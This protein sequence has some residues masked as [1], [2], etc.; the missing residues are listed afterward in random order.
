MMSSVSVPVM[1]HAVSSDV[2]VMTDGSEAEAGEGG[3]SV[4]VCSEVSILRLLA[5]LS[6][7][8][9]PASPLR[10]VPLSKFASI[11]TRLHPYRTPLWPVNVL[12]TLACR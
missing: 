5:S 8:P 6:S 3:A 4:I 2:L 12:M 9:F 1:I 10:S 11:T 7:C